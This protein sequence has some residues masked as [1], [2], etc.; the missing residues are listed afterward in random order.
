MSSVGLR[1]CAR[2][3]ASM[4]LH[5]QGIGSASSFGDVGDLLNDGQ[6]QQVTD[7]HPSKAEV[8]NDAL[9]AFLQC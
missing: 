7:Y 1:R 9:K 5:E 2:K 6:D 8:Q 3:P 4:C